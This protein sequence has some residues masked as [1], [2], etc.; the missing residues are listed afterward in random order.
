MSLKK[1][2]PHQEIYK[3][4]RAFH[5]VEIEGIIDTK[6]VKQGQIFISAGILV[7]TS[8]PGLELEGRVQ[9]L[10][11]SESNLGRTFEEDEGI[12]GSQSFDHL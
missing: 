3:I 5:Q 6:M 1:L 10:K 12:E 8:H 4:G 7:G 9:H 11:V 2:K